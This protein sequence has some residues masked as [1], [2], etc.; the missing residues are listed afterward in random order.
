VGAD[1]TISIIGITSVIVNRSVMRL[2]QHV[3]FRS[4]FVSSPGLGVPHLIY[5]VKI[6]P[7][8]ML[9]IPQGRLTAMNQ[10]KR[11]PFSRG[12]FGVES[13][14]KVDCWRRLNTL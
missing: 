1:L 2:L 8:E 13:L 10:P 6:Q 9:S 5:I 14:L 4:D 7:M 12:A 11:R 3:N